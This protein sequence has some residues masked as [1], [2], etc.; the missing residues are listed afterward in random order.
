MPTFIVSQACSQN[1]VLHQSLREQK[2]SSI[3]PFVYVKQQSLV[4]K[5][6]CSKIKLSSLKLNELVLPNFL[7]G[8][9]DKKIRIFVLR[10]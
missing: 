10:P 4:K 7:W 3:K 9:Y 8:V 6:M 5:L 1:I 2:K